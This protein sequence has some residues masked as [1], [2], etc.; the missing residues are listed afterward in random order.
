MADVEAFARDPSNG[1][2]PV[3][4]YPMLLYGYGSYGVCI[5]PGFNAN[6]LPYLNRGIVY[7]YAHIRGGG[8]QGRPWYEDH[9][10]YLNKRNTFTD[11]SAV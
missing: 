5:D 4:D 10:K 2:L 1:V 6:I 3:H 7:A 9:G 11:F 8:E